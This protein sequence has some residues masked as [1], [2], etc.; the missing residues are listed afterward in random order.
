MSTANAIEN[1]VDQNYAAFLE[2]ANDLIGSNRAGQFALLRHQEI[3]AFFSTAGEAFRYGKAHFQDR[4][5]SV[6]EVT[7]KPLDLG[8]FSHGGPYTDV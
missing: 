3:I 8:Y 7:D 5:F 2:L 6:Q 1:E 4:L